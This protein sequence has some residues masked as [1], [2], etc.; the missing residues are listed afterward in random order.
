MK[1]LLAFKEKDALNDLIRK[2]ALLNAIKHKGKARVDPVA[3]KIFSLTSETKPEVKSLYA[4]VKAVLH[5]VNNLS[6]SEQ[7]QIVGDKWPEA[8]MKEKI[9]K[10]KSLPPLPNLNKYTQVVTRFSPNPDCVLHLG[11]ARA[12][13]LSYEYASLNKGKFILRFEDTDPKVKRPSLEFYE[14]VKHQLFLT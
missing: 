8:L 14:S 6:L 1:N 2:I 13:I 11:S 4:L 12:I 9:G 3:R 10:A 7:K 5:E